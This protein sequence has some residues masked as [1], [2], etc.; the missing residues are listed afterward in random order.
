MKK[1]IKAIVLRYTTNK[2]QDIDG[3]IVDQN[4]KNTTIKFPPHTAKFIRDTA[5]EGE[6][7]EMSLDSDP[8][9]HRLA[10]IKNTNTGRSF[11]IES[12]DPPHPA[13]TGR[14]L[15]FSITEPQY[16]RGGKHGGITGVIFDNKYI[17]LHPD[18]YEGGEEGLESAATLHIKAKKRLETSGFLHEQGLPVY[19]SHEVEIETT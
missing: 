15:K 10:T 7:V 4:G 8:K 5:A 19:H 1:P 16:T 14:M 9:H 13:E 11:D 17:H 2:H 6:E 12:V 3:M 18:E